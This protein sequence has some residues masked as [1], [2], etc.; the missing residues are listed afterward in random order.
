MP[1]DKGN[2]FLYNPQSGRVEAM[3]TNGY[4]A[5]FLLIFLSTRAN[6]ANGVREWP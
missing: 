3:V 5:R 1:G 2:V 4:R 6:P